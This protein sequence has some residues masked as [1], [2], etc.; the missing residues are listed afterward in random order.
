MDMT[1]LIWLAIAVV[2]A[3]GIPPLFGIPRSKVPRRVGEE[4]YDDTVFETGFAELQEKQI[5]KGMRK[6]VSD[7]M[8]QWNKNGDI[9]SVHDIL[10]IGCGTGHL[11]KVIHDEL[12]QRGM[13]T[14]MHGVDIG[15]ASIS[16]CKTF[17]VDAGLD[18]VDVKEG[19]AANLPFEDNSM[20][21]ILSSLSL[22][23]WSKPGQS[24]EEIHRVLRVGGR[25]ILF[26]LRR[27]ARKIYHHA[28][29]HWFQPT[30]PEPLR[31][32][33]EPHSSMLAAYTIPEI[34]SFMDGS[35]WKDEQVYIIPKSFTFFI[36]AMKK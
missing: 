30:M 16:E 19:D 2:G 14:V 31:S 11:I 8:L 34:S 7:Q 4:G 22:H 3:L 29:E 25:F 24:L 32:A 17:L 28:F 6:A 20:D 36:D 35:S 21:L 1:W 27:D 13:N 10:D 18:N 9:S 26:D 12:G 33:G 15:T 5:F 23:H